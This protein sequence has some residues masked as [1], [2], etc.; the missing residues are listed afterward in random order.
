M[1]RE[2]DE[3]SADGLSK[4]VH[5]SGCVLPHR[6]IKTF[7]AVAVRYGIANFGF[8]RQPRF[9]TANEPYLQRQ[10]KGAFMKKSLLLFLV[11]VMT[12][13]FTASCT[14]K[15]EG[16]KRTGEN[17]SSDTVSTDSQIDLFPI[18][19]CVIT[20]GQESSTQMLNASREISIAVANLCG[21]TMMI[22]DDSMQTEGYEIL[23]GETNRTESRQADDELSEKSM[24]FL[25]KRY[26]KKLVILGTSESA[27]TVAVRYFLDTLLPNVAGEGNLKL[28]ANYSYTENVEAVKKAEMRRPSGCSA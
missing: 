18:D 3:P 8:M 25:I 23:V 19:N 5:A 26:D 12:G 7:E 11:L 24:A 14:G 10:N 1:K 13:I 22:R 27:T 2:I 9:R 4:P 15:N 28:D 21:R 20:R 6:E 17:I 16:E